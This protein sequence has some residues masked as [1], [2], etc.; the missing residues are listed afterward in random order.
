MLLSGNE[1]ISKGWWWNLYELISD[2]EKLNGNVVAFASNEMSN[3]LEIAQ[4]FH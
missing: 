3:N 2:I 4:I 1:S